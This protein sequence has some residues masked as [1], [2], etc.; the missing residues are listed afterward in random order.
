[1]NQG[2]ASDPKVLTERPGPPSQK[3]KEEALAARQ[4]ADQKDGQPT[5]MVKVESPFTGYFDGPAFSLSAVNATGPFDVLPKHHNFISLLVPC[6]LVIRA[7][8]G[9]EQRITIGGGLLHVKADRAV[10]FLDV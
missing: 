4:L 8:S 5:M 9:D 7:V 3:D 2:V 1:M 10:V 6:T